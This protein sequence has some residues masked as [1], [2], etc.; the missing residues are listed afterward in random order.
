HDPR[1]ACSPR[2][3]ANA[4][5]IADATTS[6]AFYGH[7]KT[8][9]ADV[10]A[11][12]LRSPATVPWNLLVDERDAGNL[13]R[14]AAT[15][16]SPVGKIVAGTDFGRQETF[17]EPFSRERYASTRVRTL[18]LAAGTYRIVVTMEGG[19]AEQRYTL[20][21]GSAERFGIA[22]VPYVL[23]A[24]HRIRALDY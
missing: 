2:G 23:G 21:V 5:A 24:I 18:R 8:G 6:W 14:P 7:L 4:I 3:E 1:F 17:Y 15:L 19:S 20:A 11:F 16:S 13:A 9:Q 12:T 10:Y 22:D